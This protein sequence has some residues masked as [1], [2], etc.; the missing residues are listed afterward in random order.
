MIHT[1]TD[2][3]MPC[4]HDE[5]GALAAPESAAV[6]DNIDGQSRAHRSPPIR[7]LRCGDRCLSS[8]NVRFVCPYWS[9]KRTTVRRE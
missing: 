2:R 4:A 7:S 3:L 1:D 5:G 6:A 9:Y 8:L